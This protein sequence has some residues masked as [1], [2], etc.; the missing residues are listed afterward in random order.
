M[1]HTYRPRSGERF[2]G[3]GRV[4]WQDCD[5][6]ASGMDAIIIAHC[7]LTYLQFCMSEQN[8]RHYNVVVQSLQYCIKYD[9]HWGSW[10]SKGTHCK[11][12][13]RNPMASV[14][15]PI[16]IWMRRK[17]TSSGSFIHCAC[18]VPSPVCWAVVN[19]LHVHVNTRIMTDVS[20]WLCQMFMALLGLSAER[21]P[22]TAAC[23]SKLALPAYGPAFA[24][25][26]VS[27]AVTVIV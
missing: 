7:R 17:P 6:T 22:F 4:T 18:V 16:L 11:I 13:Q 15:A 24:C 12:Q 5:L 8:R 27:L 25:R 23:Y 19:F 1:H 3:T 9:I 10:Y 2:T 26:R 14:K 21:R 20:V